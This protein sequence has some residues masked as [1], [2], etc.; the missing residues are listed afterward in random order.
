MTKNTLGALAAAAAIVAAGAFPLAAGAA[1][2][3]TGQ[4]QTY[5]LNVITTR[6]FD[7]GEFDGVL[8]LTISPDGYVNGSYHDVDQGLPKV[9]TGALEPDGRIWLDIGSSGQL[10]LNGTFRNGVL[11]A[12]GQIPTSDTLYFDAA[13]RH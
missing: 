2:V 1:T 4:S 6:Q 8:R 5:T 7:A 3:T 9:V 10:H 12:V 11:H 13:P